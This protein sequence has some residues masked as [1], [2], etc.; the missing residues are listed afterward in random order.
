[1]EFEL[2][3]LVALPL[4]FA[5][6]WFGRGFESRTR[7]HPTTPRCRARTFAASTCC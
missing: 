2:W 3:Y 1:M 6:G 5:A 7:A 4:V